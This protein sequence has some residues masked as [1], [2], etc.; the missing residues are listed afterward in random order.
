MRLL[1]GFR[2]P[3]PLE[4]RGLDL[5]RSTLHR[6]SLVGIPL[7]V[8]IILLL[9]LTPL[10]EGPANT[11]GDLCT[12]S[13]PCKLGHAVT[14]AALGFAAGAW[15][16]SSEAARRAPRRTLVA[17]VLAIWILAAL[18]EQAQEFVG[19]NAELSDWLV[20][21]AGAIAGL[22]GGSA[23]LRLLLRVRRN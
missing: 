12:F 22:L 8:A 11:L 23:L 17:I 4:S 3:H 16:A 14:F 21:M 19:R 10:G 18:D 2:L 13:L 9:T 5:R 1:A 15:Y 6:W 7:S 20:D